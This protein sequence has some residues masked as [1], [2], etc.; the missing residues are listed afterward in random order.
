MC[1]ICKKSFKSYQALGGYKAHHDKGDATA[2]DKEFTAVDAVVV[3]YRDRYGGI[4]LDYPILNPSL[5]GYEDQPRN[6]PGHKRLN[7][8]RFFSKGQALGGHRR[9]CKGQVPKVFDLDPLEWVT[10]EME[11]RKGI[12]GREKMSLPSHDDHSPSYDSSG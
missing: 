10:E 11:S 7:C 5:V 8:N 12:I 6:S 1:S 3:G 9:H 4:G 2:E